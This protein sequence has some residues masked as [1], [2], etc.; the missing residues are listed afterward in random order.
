MLA[1]LQLPAKW[2]LSLGFACLLFSLAAGQGM[3]EETAE[4]RI[5]RLKRELAEAEVAAAEEAAQAASGE[6]VDGSESATVDIP[7]GA[8]VIVE[9]AEGGGGSGFIAEIRER[10]FFVTNIHVLAGA[11]GATI[12]TADG[13]VLALP[14]YAFLSRNRDLAILPLVWTGDYL[15][16]SSSLSFDEV[17]I[18]DAITVMGNSDGVGVA[19]RLHGAVDGL[20][21]DQIE[22]SAKFV[23]GNSGSPIVH[24]ERGTVIGIVSHMRDLSKKTKWTE[25][26]EQADIRRYGF[27]M[28]GEISW[29]RAS[30]N[31]IFDEGERLEAFDERTELLTRTIYMLKNNRTIMTGYREHASLG[32]L[33]VP[34]EEGFNWDRGLA[35]SNNVRKLERFVNNLRNELISDRE[36]TERDLKLSFFRS[37]FRELDRLRD[38]YDEQ[39]KLVSF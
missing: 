6:G 19:T 32:Y 23:P 35:S 10:L 34:F 14:D 31:Q 25:D 12:R 7:M 27:R 24:N 15:E 3:V 20:G 30:L 8:L 11:R 18:G 17:A 36:I 28:D 29:E 4:E 22:I 13:Q 16:I 33:F 5:E 21:P 9:G 37:R 26:S 1:R 39:L 2:I 38:Y